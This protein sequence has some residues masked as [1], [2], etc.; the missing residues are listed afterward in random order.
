MALPAFGIA[1]MLTPTL[2][3][4][5][6]PDLPET[7]VLFALV[8]EDL[9]RRARLL[10]C[11]PDANLST[12]ALVHET[13]L[14]IAAA[15]LAP[16]DQAH[17]FAIAAR[18]MRHVLLNAARDANALKRGGDLVPITLGTSVA[19]NGIDTTELFALDQALTLLAE[20]HPRLARV[21]ELHFFAGLCFGQIAQLL[22]VTERTV[23]R[24]WREA[25]A[26]LY[27]DLCIA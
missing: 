3:I 1:I 17:F 23:Q 12:T 8:Y 19:A 24:D 21:V 18:A 13:Y 22:D 5:H 14:K 6:L 10:R 4:P 26:L 15:E 2:P 9:R 16:N 25:R 20:K 27:A 7:D 11:M